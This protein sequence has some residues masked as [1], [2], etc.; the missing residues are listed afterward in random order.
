[1]ALGIKASSVMSL[2]FSI[3]PSSCHVRVSWLRLICAPRTPSDMSK[4]AS[5]V[6][7]LSDDWPLF[8]NRNA[9]LIYL[10]ERLAGR[11]MRERVRTDR[12]LT[13]KGV[14]GIAAGMRLFIH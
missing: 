4:Q 6:G 14:H 1:M 12:H 11:R 9:E 5:A 8:G 7:Q 3:H 10:M 2:D 13:S